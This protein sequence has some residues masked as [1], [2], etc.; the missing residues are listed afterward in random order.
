MTQKPLRPALALCLWALRLSITHADGR[1]NRAAL[2]GSTTNAYVV[3]ALQDHLMRRAAAHDHH[4]RAL[5]QHVTTRTP[6]PPRRHAPRRRHH[7]A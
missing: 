6:P 4:A 7:A 5:R 1:T 2:T 3:N